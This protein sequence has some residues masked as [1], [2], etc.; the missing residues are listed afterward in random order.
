MDLLEYENVGLDSFFDSF[1]PQLTVCDK[2]YTCTGDDQSGYVW[3]SDVEGT[4]GV[5]GCRVDSLVGCLGERVP[6]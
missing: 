3:R 1:Q 6:R 5:R 2:T 4:A